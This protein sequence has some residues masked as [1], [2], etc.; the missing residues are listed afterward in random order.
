MKINKCFLGIALFLIS[1][2]PVSCAPLTS[3]PSPV[4]TTA[5]PTV[6]PAPA[7]PAVSPTKVIVP[8]DWVET[9]SGLFVSPD[10]IKLQEQVA[11]TKDYTLVPEGKGMVLEVKLADGT[12]TKIPGFVENPDG[13]MTLTI[14]GQAVPVTSLT[15]G[16]D[17]KPQWLAADGSTYSFDGTKIAK[18]AVPTWEKLNAADQAILD[19]APATVERV[20]TA[21]SPILKDIPNLPVGSYLTSVNGQLE[22]D[23]MN[24][25]GQ[26]VTVATVGADGKSF[27]EA[28]AIKY[29]LANT[30]EVWKNY[31]VPYEFFGHGTSQVGKLN[32]KPFPE[33]TLIGLDIVKEPISAFRGFNRTDLSQEA[34]TLLDANPG[35][36]G[37]QLVG[38]F[39]VKYHNEF[40]DFIW[41]GEVWEF[42][43]KD[44]VTVRYVSYIYGAKDATD[45]VPSTAPFAVGWVTAKSPAPPLSI[46][47]KD[48]KVNAILDQWVLDDEPPADAENVGFV[49]LN[50][51]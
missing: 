1:L 32:G 3:T 29:K 42:L 16:P 22:Y 45:V 18:D 44:K 26:P 50:H 9:G 28:D 2:L 14:D 25:V 6:S 5:T 46:I 15:F 23:F 11:V 21:D 4:S 34:Q 12:T 24:A 40:G 10:V 48:P 37:F 49:G 39:G 47:E 30:P 7:E 51:P 36:Q 8:A 27:V 41:P 35:L 20:I 43:L 31:I 38:Y 33:N 13:T 17:G 19:A